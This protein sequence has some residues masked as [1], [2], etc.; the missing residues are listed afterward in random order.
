MRVV[1]GHCELISGERL[2][3]R[4]G[5]REWVGCEGCVGEVDVKGVRDGDGDGDGDGRVCLLE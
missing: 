2:R 1:C 4:S 5:M 3:K